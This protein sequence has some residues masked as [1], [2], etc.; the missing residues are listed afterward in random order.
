MNLAPLL[1]APAVVQIHT[2]AAVVALA[3]GATVV[4][5]RKGTAVHVGLGRVWLALMTAIAATSFWITDL[6]L[7]HFSPIH[8]LSIVTLATLPY[9][10]WARRRGDLR[11]HA[12]AMLSV[13]AGLFIAGAFTLVPGRILHAVFFGEARAAGKAGG[14]ETAGEGPPVEQTSDR[15]IFDAVRRASF[16]G[17]A[18]EG[19][20]TGRRPGQ[21][22]HLVKMRQLYDE[23]KLLFGGPFKVE[24]GGMSVAHDMTG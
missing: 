21:D 22:D 18:V 15:E 5:L 23:G 14:G 1:A 20:R 3:L 19:Q 24:L 11:G 13:F 12:I 6:R 9:A 2:A 10:V 17:R 16:S 8:V 4:T 7:G